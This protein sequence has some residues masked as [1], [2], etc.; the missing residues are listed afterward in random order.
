MLILCVP[1]L[2][3]V[4]AWRVRDNR[5]RFFLAALCFA[6]NLRHDRLL[7]LPVAARGIVTAHPFFR[8]FHHLYAVVSALCGGLSRQNLAGQLR[9]ISGTQ[10]G[11]YKERRR[12]PACMVGFSYR[13]KRRSRGMRHEKLSDWKKSQRSAR[14]AAPAHIPRDLRT[15]RH[16]LWLKLGDLAVAHAEH[17]RAD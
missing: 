12:K 9:R 2:Y 6:A 4:V 3:T 10:N 1:D 8:H 11:Y 7:R 14:A 16:Q 13:K 15:C 17:G 5:P